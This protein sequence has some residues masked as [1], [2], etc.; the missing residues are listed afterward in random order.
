MFPCRLPAMRQLGYGP[1]MVCLEEEQWG[2]EFELKCKREE[3]R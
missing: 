1:G 3:S 2:I